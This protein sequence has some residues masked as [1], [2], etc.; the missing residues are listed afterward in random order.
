MS[1]VQVII[2]MDEY[3]KLKSIENSASVKEITPDEL[4]NSVSHLIYEVH[5]KG[6]I[7]RECICID[8]KITVSED[9]NLINGRRF[10]FER[11]NNA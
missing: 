5:Q 8:I 1:K 2:D 7:P 9:R 4:S 3:E 6:V 10:K 11:V